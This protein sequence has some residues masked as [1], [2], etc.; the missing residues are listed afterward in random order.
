MKRRSEDAVD[1]VAAYGRMVLGEREKIRS[2]C[3]RDSVVA[4]VAEM[5]EDALRRLESAKMMSATMLKIHVNESGVVAA[6]RKSMGALEYVKLPVL[7]REHGLRWIQDRLKFAMFGR[8]RFVH[9]KVGL[10]LRSVALHEAGQ[11]A[12]ASAPMPSGLLAMQERREIEDSARPGSH[13]G[14]SAPRL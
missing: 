11:M 14:L 4:D 6:L 7:P 12:R 10:L 8:G 1:D 13:S 9:R 5:A 2:R 3:D